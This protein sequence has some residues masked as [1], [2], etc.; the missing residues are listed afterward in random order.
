M[1][2]IKTKE[3]IEKLRGGGRILAGILRQITDEIKPGV[4]TLQ[5]EELAC[6]LINRAGGRPS[7]KGY[8][9]RHEL[10]AFPTAI[11]ASI[12]DEV[13][14]APAIPHRILKNGD[15]IGIDIGME[16]PFKIG[17]EGLYTD[18]AA[19]VG[20]GK[21]SR[22]V[23]KLIEITKQS[24]SLG[25][26]AVRPGGVISDIGRAVQRY[27]E[28]R[29]FSVVRD[30]VGHGVGLKVHEEPAV[31]NY[32]TAGGKEIILKPGM[33]L[34]IEPMINIGGFGIETG[35]DGLTI[36][37]EDGSLSAHFEHTVAVTDKGVKIL[38]SL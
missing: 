30:L 14:H 24:L 36:K 27:A 33:V 12:N 23:A 8:K 13:V 3:Q 6:E 31:P 28:A 25:I 5:L 32:E 7:F 34:A 19:T 22:E 1:I 10:Q 16:W 38:T 17:E 18:T 26:Q 2:T 4:S 20:V 9:S 35:A 21:I 29:G 37:T 15:I 11:C